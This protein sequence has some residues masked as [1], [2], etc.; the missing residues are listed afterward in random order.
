MNHEYYQQNFLKYLMERISREQYV[1]Y[2]I[3]YTP[4]KDLRTLCMSYQA[5]KERQPLLFKELFSHFSKDIWRVVA[6][7]LYFAPSSTITT[8]ELAYMVATFKDAIEEVLEE[9]QVMPKIRTETLIQSAL[10]KHVQ[11]GQ[12]SDDEDMYKGILQQYNIHIDASL[13]EIREEKFGPYKKQPHGEKNTQ[14]KIV[15]QRA[16]LPKVDSSLRAE[17]ERRVLRALPALPLKEAD[18]EIFPQMEES[19]LDLAIKTYMHDIPQK[20]F[21]EEISGVPHLTQLCGERVVRRLSTILQ[22]MPFAAQFAYTEEGN[23]YRHRLEDEKKHIKHVVRNSIYQS[24]VAQRVY[25]GLGLEQE[26]YPYVMP[27]LL[28]AY[29]PGTY[30]QY[31][32]APQNYVRLALYVFQEVSHLRG[33]HVETVIQNHVL[34]TLSQKMSVI[35]PEILEVC[36][37]VDCIVKYIPHASLA[38]PDSY[39]LC[40]WDDIQKQLPAHPVFTAMDRKM[41]AK[42]GK[43]QACDIRDIFEVLAEVLL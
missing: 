10:H 5:A 14:E 29:L 7:E 3:K 38:V 43:V 32:K 20:E 18:T 8:K 25:Q 33:L 16:T 40:S 31:L 11:Y 21:I 13:D 19:A 26:L 28:E 37:Y 9:V 1:D 36:K 17:Q 27:M 12:W 15:S 22:L 4:T 2:F 30:E 23:L 42:L 35:V 6:E 24:V 39:F 41:R 34:G